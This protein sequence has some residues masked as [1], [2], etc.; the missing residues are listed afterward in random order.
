MLA[1]SILMINKL[2]LTFQIK[3]ALSVLTAAPIVFII[4]AMGQYLVDPETDEFDRMILVR[5][6]LYATGLVMAVSTIW[7]F[8]E[9]FAEVADFPLYLMFPVFLTFFG[10]AQPLI[11][12]RYK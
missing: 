9:N 4:W 6:V 8:L 5:S 11:R 10:L 1:V 12:S 7:G 3:A 2:D